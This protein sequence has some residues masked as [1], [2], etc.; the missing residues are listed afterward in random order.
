MSHKPEH[1]KYGELHEAT[2]RKVIYQN[3]KS[4][5][6]VYR[7]KIDVLK[8]KKDL[9]KLIISDKF[10]NKLNSE[11]AIDRK[12]QNEL[13]EA[14][15]SYWDKSELILEEENENKFADG[16]SNT[17]ITEAKII[18]KAVDMLV[19]EGK[20]DGSFK[21]YEESRAS[22]YIDRHGVAYKGGNNYCT[23]FFKKTDGKVG[24][25]VINRF[26]ANN[27]NFIPEWQKQEGNKPLWYVCISDLLELDTPDEWKKY[28]D[29][30]RCLARVK[31]MSK[32]ELTID[33]IFD[34]RMTSPNKKEIKYMKVDSLTKG[35]EFYAKHKSRKIE[36]T[37]FGKVR[38]KH[39]KLWSG[40]A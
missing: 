17:K 7:R 10:P 30:E 21:C 4:V 16:K 38:R 15:L 26:N 31:K 19:K 34:A 6:T 40:K 27:P 33:Y 24:W 39:K 12:Q 37:S 28:T 18:K 11:I 1:S 3:A 8:I 9:D 29:N 36:L 20:C 25:E 14:I 13:R 23:D 22:I 2:K 35:L 5:I 32:Y